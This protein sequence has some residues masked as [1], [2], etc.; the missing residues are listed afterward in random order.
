[1]L[2]VKDLHIAVKV[3]ICPPFAYILPNRTL[4]DGKTELQ[5]CVQPPQPTT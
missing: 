2:L 3:R 4:R 5:T 1:M